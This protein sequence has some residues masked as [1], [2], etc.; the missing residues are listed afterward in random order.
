MKGKMLG[1][2][3][4]WMEERSDF[5]SQTENTATCIIA[6]IS[7]ISLARRGAWLA[8]RPLPLASLK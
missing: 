5:G 8:L 3:D 6:A 2:M 7:V 1:R 4:G